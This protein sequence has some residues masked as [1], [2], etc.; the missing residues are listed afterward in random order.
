MENYLKIGYYTVGGVTYQNEAKYHPHPKSCNQEQ[1]SL[2]QKIL[3]QLS[4][5]QTCNFNENMAC[6]SK[7]LKTPPAGLK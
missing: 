1:N 6:V 7:M 2:N 3:S 4:H 5:L